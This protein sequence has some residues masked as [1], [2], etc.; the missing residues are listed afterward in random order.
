MTALSTQALA[1]TSATSQ[2]FGIVDM[3]RVLQ[4][5]DAAKSIF[6]QMDAKR[7]SYQAEIAREEDKI[8]SSEESLEK[9][10]D[11]LSKGAFEAKQKA[12]EEKVI[13]GQKMVQN[14]RQVLDQAFGS[15]MNGLRHSAAQIV[16][17][18]AKDKHY[19]AVFTDDAVMMSTPDLDMTDEVIKQMNEKVKDVR[20]DWK[21]ASESV[22]AS[23]GAG[24]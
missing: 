15:A 13:D 16:A 4:T 17:H 12:I 6:K 2:T 22:A 8:R 18:I 1:A 11:T 9:Q 10:K 19:S 21:K 14:R 7:K 5:T 23:A 24:K 20:V 3:N